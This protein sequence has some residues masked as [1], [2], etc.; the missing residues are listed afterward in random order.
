M[1]AQ[2]KPLTAEDAGKSVGRG[3]FFESKSSQAAKTFMISTAEEAEEAEVFL[4]CNVGQPFFVRLEDYRRVR[5]NTPKTSASSASQG[6]WFCVCFWLRVRRA[7]FPVLLFPAGCPPDPKLSLSAN[8]M[9]GLHASWAV[10][11]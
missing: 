11:Q 3:C 1:E 4:G 6:L 5:G 8:R 2:P 10:Q 7:A 9:S